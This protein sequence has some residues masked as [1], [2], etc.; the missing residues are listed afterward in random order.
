M[1]DK[2]HKK[3]TRNP[4]DGPQD[5]LSIGIRISGKREP[6]MKMARG[7]ALATSERGAAS[8]GA[9]EPPLLA[10]TTGGGSAAQSADGTDD[11]DGGRGAGDDGTWLLPLLRLSPDAQVGRV[12]GAMTARDVQPLPMR[13]GEAKRGGDGGAVTA[14]S[15]A[16]NEACRSRRSSACGRV[17][18]TRAENS[19]A[20]RAA[21]GGEGSSM[22]IVTTPNSTKSAYIF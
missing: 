7:S 9:S 4:A 3:S 10:T 12:V 18:A 17:S 11:I 1:S 8:A 2:E 21:G 22:R 19:T 6:P 13:V 14:A 5:S 16:A 15:S 20:L